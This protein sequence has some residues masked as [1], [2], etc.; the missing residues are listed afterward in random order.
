MYP[1][2]LQSYSK[3]TFAGGGGVNSGQPSK[4]Q[5]TAA[6]KDA[7]RRAELAKKQEGQISY[8]IHATTASPPAPALRSPASTAAA[9]SMFL[10][11]AI[12]HTTLPTGPRR[13]TGYHG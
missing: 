11:A 9:T 13:S 7:V 1:K 10:H 3:G 2:D 5:M 8:M 4:Q 12:S 6:Q